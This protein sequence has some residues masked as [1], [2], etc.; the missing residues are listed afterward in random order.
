MVCFAIFSLFFWKISQT[1]GRRDKNQ[2]KT[3]QQPNKGAS[4][5]YVT[6]DSDFFPEVDTHTRTYTHTPPSPQPLMSLDITIFSA[7]KS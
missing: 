1:S 6:G 4:I 3:A 7:A 5:N 2:K